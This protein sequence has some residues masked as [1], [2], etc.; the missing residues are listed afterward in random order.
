MTNLKDDALNHIIKMC[1]NSR[2]RTKRLAFIEKRAQEAL[3]NIPYDRDNFDIPDQMIK[4]P[5]E[6]ELEIRNLK[7]QILKLRDKLEDNQIWV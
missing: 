1:R 2:T 6:Y 7:Q 4:S 3:D 5:S